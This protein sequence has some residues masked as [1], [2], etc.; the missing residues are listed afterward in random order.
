[1]SK[2]YKGS[3]VCGAIQL[4]V[5][6][7]PDQTI[8]CFCHDC[9]KNSGN[10][11]QITACYDLSNVKIID[12]ENQIGEYVITKTG[13]GKPKHKEYCLKCGCTIRTIVESLP[14]KNIIRPTLLEEGFEDFTPQSALFEDE[15][16]RYTKGVHCEYY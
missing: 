10:L 9:R 14:G 4:E 8:I 5:T 1:M 6:G 16:A 15:K 12:P 2:T 7:S 11:G 3:C 13:S